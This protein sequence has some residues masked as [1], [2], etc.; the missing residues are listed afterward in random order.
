[1][2]LGI[3]RLCSVVYLSDMMAGS[4]QVLVEQYCH[5]RQGIEA[6]DGSGTVCG[7]PQRTSAKCYLLWIC[8]PCPHLFIIVIHLFMIIYVL[9][10]CRSCP[11]CYE[12]ECFNKPALSM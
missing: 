5:A 2:Y 6:V 12:V 11:L 4:C 8:L 3:F 1:M 10:I 7:C 9:W